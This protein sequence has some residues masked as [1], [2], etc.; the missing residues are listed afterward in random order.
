MS[1]DIYCYKS[2]LGKPDLAEAKNLIEIEED[3]EAIP[4]SGTKSKLAAALTEYNPRLENFK[5]D[6]EEIAELQ[7][8]TTDEARKAF[9]HIELNTPENDLATQI[10]LFENSVYISVPYWYS[11][12]KQTEVFRKISDYL[13]IIRQTA[14][15]FVYDPQTENVYDPLTENIFEF[16]EKAATQVEK[17]TIKP[18]TGSGRKPWRKFW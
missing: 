17:T 9:S 7:G 10:T 12:D 3:T 15:F 4:D 16:G 18:L 14:G 11:G 6:Y 2:K 1:Y 5:F 13:K 8:I